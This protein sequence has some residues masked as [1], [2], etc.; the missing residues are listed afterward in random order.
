MWAIIIESDRLTGSDAELAASPGSELCSRDCTSP[1]RAHPAM[2]DII[3]RCWPDQTFFL[4]IGTAVPVDPWSATAVTLLG[5][6]IHAMPPSRASAA[7]TAL[8]IAASLAGRLAAVDRGKT[9]L[10]TAIA[11]YEAD[12]RRRGF[13]AVQASTTALDATGRDIIAAGSAHTTKES[14]L[15]ATQSP[16]M[17]PVAGSIIDKNARMA[18]WCSSSDPGAGLTAKP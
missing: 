10:L 15:A 1:K 5:D 4:T 12:M 11:E 9:P 17:Y 6:A 13:S 18:V 16:A 8:V 7:N 3:E 2:R 14:D